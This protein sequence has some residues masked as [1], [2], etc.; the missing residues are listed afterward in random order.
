ML[1]QVCQSH[2]THLGHWQ[3]VIK[4]SSVRND[5]NTGG[6]QDIVH[7]YVDTYDRLH[8]VTSLQWKF[9]S[10]RNTWPNISNPNKIWN[11]WQLWSHSINSQP[12]AFVALK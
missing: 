11:S 10:K 1:P 2:E 3:S 7:K 4:R 6:L 9:R 5:Y 8:S 12:I